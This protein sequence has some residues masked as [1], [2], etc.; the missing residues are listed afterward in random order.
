MPAALFF[1]FG[2]GASA[3]LLPLMLQLAFGLDALSSG[4][5]TFAGALGA[6][7][8]KPLARGFLHRFG[9]RRLLIVNGV[10]ASAVL[11]ASALFTPA[12]PHFVITVV[13]LVGGFLRSLQF[14]S[15]SAITYAEI[16]PRQVGSATGMASVGQ[17]VSVSLGVAVGAMVVEMSE[18][19]RGHSVPETSDFSAAFVVV[20][21]MSMASAL[22]MFRLPADAGDEMSGRRLPPREASSA[23][24]GPTGG[25]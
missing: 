12:T 21:L 18:W 17:Q 14:T 23:P 8:V 4:L 15:L 3:F 13:L 19:A 22:L 1:R 7:A 9:F 5:I 16:E 20:G 11:L 6:L 2:V 25:G 24:A 10:L